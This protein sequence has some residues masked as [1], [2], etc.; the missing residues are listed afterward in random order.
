MND[1]YTVQCNIAY[2]IIDQSSIKDALASTQGTGITY[3]LS[4]T[5]LIRYH[6]ICIIFIIVFYLN[7]NRVTVNY[8]IKTR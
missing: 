2:L 7:N 1:A 6:T 5:I 4:F 8:N 3:Y